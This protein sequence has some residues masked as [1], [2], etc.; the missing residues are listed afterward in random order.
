LIGVFGF[1]LLFIKDRLLALYFYLWIVIPY[2]AVSFF[3]KILF[4]R[5]LIFFASI[6]T[7]LGI[8]FIASQKDIKLR[9]LLIVT[10]LVSV[11]YLNY[12][13]IFNPAV[14]LLP[15]VDRGQY[16]EG[17]PAGWGMSEIVS[18]AREKSKEKPVVLLAEGNFG[19]SGDVLDSLLSR[20]D[21]ISIQGY[22]PL[23]DTELKANQ[24]LL[25]DHYVYVVF[26][27]RDTFP[28]DWPIRLIKKYDKPGKHSSNY[29]YELTN[30]P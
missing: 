24:K 29:L 17:W 12:A 9:L 18:F 25:K 11:G 2:G 21:K 22:W 4:P 15:P 23:G 3:S 10:F 1:I 6:F 20:N 8:Y 16:L 14:A 27:H 26:A 5:Y 7:F 19:T 13:I 28:K 30:N